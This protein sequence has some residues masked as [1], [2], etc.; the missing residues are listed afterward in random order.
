MYYNVHLIKE[1][2]IY[3]SANAINNVNYKAEVPI[4]T[5]PKYKLKLTILISIQITNILH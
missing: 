2:K 1:K 4:V 3:F 5:K